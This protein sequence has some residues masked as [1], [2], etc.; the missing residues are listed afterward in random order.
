MKSWKRTVLQLLLL[1]LFALAGASSIRGRRRPF[2][3][4]KAP[5]GQ[6]AI[7]GAVHIHSAQFVWTAREC[8]CKNERSVSLPDRSSVACI[9]KFS[10]VF[11]SYCTASD[12][13]RP[14]N[15]THF[16]FP[17]AAALH[18]LHAWN[19]M[20][21]GVWVWVWISLARTYAWELRAR[22]QAGRA[23][24]CTVGLYSLTLFSLPSSIQKPSQTMKSSNQLSFTE[25]ALR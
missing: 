19:V 12:Q 3:S 17:N 10:P 2:R 6:C 23:Y 22:R 5:A 1:C 21:P 24:I 11:V 25:T 20:P 8:R 4:I 16:T 7:C 14:V 9:A 18:I 15:E 13:R